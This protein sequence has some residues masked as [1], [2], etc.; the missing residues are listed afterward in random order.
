LR[1]PNLKRLCALTALGNGA[2]GHSAHADGLDS[3]YFVRFDSVDHSW[4][5][6]GT[7]LTLIMVINYLLNFAVIGLPAIQLAS[8]PVR[9]VA[10]GLVLLT[11]LGQVADRVGAIVGIFL[12]MP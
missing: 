4:A 11:I 10:S 12:S 1:R 9:R 8:A 7:V 3:S 5:Y 6:F 2:F